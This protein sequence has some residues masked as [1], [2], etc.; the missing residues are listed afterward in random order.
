MDIDPSLKVLFYN[1]TSDGNLAS[2]PVEVE[3]KRANFVKHEGQ[4]S[5]LESYKQVSSWCIPVPDYSQ[6]ISIDGK[7]YFKF[8]IILSTEIFLSLPLWYGETGFG[9]ILNTQK[10]FYICHATLDSLKL[11][12]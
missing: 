7:F 8:R 5:S 1:V 9:D 2:E 11:V 10:A 12:D 3:L 6:W 4:P